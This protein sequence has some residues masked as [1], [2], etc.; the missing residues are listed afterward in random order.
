MSEFTT[1]DGYCSS[2]AAHRLDFDGASRQH[3]DLQ[4]RSTL[5]CFRKARDS[6]VRVVQLVRGPRSHH[7]CVVCTIHFTYIV[8]TGRF[9]NILY[10][11]NWLGPYFD[12]WEKAKNNGFP[13]IQHSNYFSVYIQL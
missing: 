10:C 6:D 12:G 3:S 8:C 1:E 13:Q 9:G 7:G 4:H 11:S 2:F 5:W